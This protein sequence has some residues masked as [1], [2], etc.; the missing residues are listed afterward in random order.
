MAYLAGGGLRVQDK[1]V[2]PHRLQRLGCPSGSSVG[3]SLSWLV[4]RSID[5]SVG[6]SVGR[7]GGLLVD[8]GLVTTFSTRWLI[9]TVYETKYD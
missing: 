3:R 7:L 4:G 8:G 5:R 6:R 9:R 1:P 2:F